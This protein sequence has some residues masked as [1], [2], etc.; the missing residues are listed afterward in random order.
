MTEG[1]A[2]VESISSLPVNFAELTIDPKET[3][4]KDQAQTNN[5]P[6]RDVADSHIGQPSCNH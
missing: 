1:T 4:D 3:R 6:E 2:H 5:P